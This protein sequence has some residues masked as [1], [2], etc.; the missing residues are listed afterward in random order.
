M[1]KK[2]LTYEFIDPNS[3]GEIENI[4][5]DMMIKKLLTLIKS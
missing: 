3:P 5:F 4:L 2:K 1:A